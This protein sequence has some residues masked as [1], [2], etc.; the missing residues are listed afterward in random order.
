[1]KSNLPPEQC[2]GIIDSTEARVACTRPLSLQFRL[3]QYTTLGDF[4]Y[5]ELTGLG[6]KHP[7]FDLWTGLPSN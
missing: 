6:H 7:K 2:A 4:K 5:E 1:M 3:N